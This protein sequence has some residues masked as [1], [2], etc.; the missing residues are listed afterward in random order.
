MRLLEY[1]GKELFDQYGI[2]IPK[3]LLAHRLEEAKEYTKKLGYPLVLKSQLTVGGRGKAGAI[4]KCK[5]E[6]ELESK[7][8]ELLHKEVKGEYPRGILLEQMANIKK[9]IYLSLFLNRGKRRYSLISSAEGGVEIES[10]ENKVV[11]DLPIEGLSPQVAEEIGQKLGLI[12]KTVVS[13]VDFT[14]KLSKLVIEKEA[15]LAEINPMAILDDDSIMALDSKVIIDDNAMFRHPELKKYEHVSELEK[16]A[17]VSGFSLVQ[18]DGNMAII[19]NGA[20][21]VMA[22]LDMV[23]DAG[24]KAGAFLDFGGRATT[25][26]IYEALKVISRIQSIEAILVNLFGGIVRTNLVAQAILDAYNENLINVPVFARIS[27]AESEKAREMLQ[28]SRAKLYNT[29]EEAIQ[30]AVAAVYKK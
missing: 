22:T 16:Q 19:G 23:S 18:L 9:E 3:S 25:E 4:A 8:N 13:F 1:Q 10:S 5:N 24:G 17:E 7:F 20:G 6:T 11:V 2:R 29:V 28:G 27:G 14:T 12:G 15:E 30:A 26:T 21:L